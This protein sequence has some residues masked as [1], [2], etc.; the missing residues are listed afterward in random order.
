MRYNAPMDENAPLQVSV[1]HQKS[2]PAP[3]AWVIHQGDETAPIA[4]SSIA[5]KTMAAARDAGRRALPGIKA[6]LGKT[7]DA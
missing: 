3:F 1:K 5:F 7:I 4:R 2:D 6:K